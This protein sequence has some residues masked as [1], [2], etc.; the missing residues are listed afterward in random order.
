[1]SQVQLPLPKES[2]IGRH[3]Q[4][5][6]CRVI[7]GYVE[8]YGQ[9]NDGKSPYGIYASPGLVRFDSGGQAGAERGMIV[10]DD[11]NMVA[12][13]GTQL[14][15]IT[16]AG[17]LTVVGT[18]N[19]TGR[20]TMARNMNGT[21][22]I[23]IV[24]EEAGTPYYYLLQG[25]TLTQPTEANLSPPNSITYLRGYFVWSALDGKITSS[26]LDS[27]TGIDA[28]AFDY[29]NSESDS[30]V[31]VYASV[32]YLYIFGTRSLEIW[33]ATGT[34]P[35]PFGPVQQNIALG[36]LARHSVAETEKGL[37]WVDHKGM[38][39]YGRDGGAQRVST[40]SVERAIASLSAADQA[41]ITGYIAVWQGHQYYILNSTG[42]TWVYDT[43]ANRWYQRNSYG[44]DRWV[45]S[46]NIWFA[47]NYVAGSYQN[48][49]LYRMDPEAYSDDSQDFILEIWCQQTHNFPGGVLLDSL[50]I[51]V[52]SGVGNDAGNLAAQDPKILIDYSDDGGKTFAGERAVSIG[53]TG[54]YRRMVRTG[55]WGRTAQKGRIWRFR[56]SASVLRGVLQASIR[57]RPC[58]G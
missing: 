3:G 42:W 14:C 30:N 36:L 13:L 1:M 58:N 12:L 48:G 26:P 5:A 45:P 25:G 51:D 34:I 16:S 4:D 31:R 37:L 18:I 54:D 17:V 11:N 56:A 50:D 8:T 24:G 23:G 35:F 19:G 53:R 2:T 40:H 44:Y 10:L 55:R 6:N 39:R 27:G 38:V 46:N 22:Q 29:A 47:G 43:D 52:L 49:K 9:E 32:G 15:N 28:L 57:A 21:P 7:N 41:D 33:Q 20:V